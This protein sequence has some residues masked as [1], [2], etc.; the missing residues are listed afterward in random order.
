MSKT[1]LIV[2]NTSLA[3]LLGAAG[4]IS[5]LSFPLTAAP[6]QVGERIISVG[7][8]AGFDLGDVPDRTKAQLRAG[9]EPFVGEDLSRDTLDKLQAVLDS[10]GKFGFVMRRDPQTG[11]FTLKVQALHSASAV[12]VAADIANTFPPPEGSVRRIRVGSKAVA[13][14]LV[15]QVHAEYPQLAKDARIQG[16]VTF[17]ILIG[18]DG[19]VKYTALISG[20]PL[21]VQA[22][23]DAVRQWLYKPT[24]LNGEPTEVITTVDVNF[25]LAP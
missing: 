25:T 1:S 2:A 11:E 10:A 22:A 16:T 13:T 9:L 5:M 12:A 18:T 21:L 6:Q 14:S 8:V 19:M 7:K 23:Q 20:H 24:L 17:A 3:L 4:W 15:A